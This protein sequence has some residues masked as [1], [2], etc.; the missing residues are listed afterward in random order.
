MSQT[1]TYLT[2][3]LAMLAFGV[4]RGVYDSN[5]FAAFFDVV[6]SRYHASAAGFNLMIAFLFGCFAPTVLGWIKAHYAMSTGLFALSLAYLCGF[7]IVCAASRFHKKG[8]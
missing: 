4:F 5:N 3:C 8:E 7:V 2:C 1:T 6:E